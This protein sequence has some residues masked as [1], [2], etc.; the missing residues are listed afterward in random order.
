M[1]EEKFIEMKQQDFKYHL[2]KIIELTYDM[3]FAEAMD[4]IATAQTEVNDCLCGQSVY[5]TPAE[6]LVDYF[7][8]PDSFLWAFL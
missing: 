7:S 3:G 2:A 8:L 4:I 1:T 6:V 5:K